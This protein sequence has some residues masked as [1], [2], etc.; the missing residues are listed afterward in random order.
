[1]FYN[2]GGGM[3]PADY[4]AVS[5]NNRGAFGNGEEW[6]FL[7]F[8]LAFAGNGNWGGGNNGYSYGVQQG[9]DQASIM[10]GLQGIQSTLT[11]YQIANNDNMN[12]LAMSLQQCCCQNQLAT[13]NLGAAV[14]SESCATRQVVNDG[15]R[16][17]QM[18]NFQSTQQIVG[19]IN[20]VG[21]N[22]DNKLCQ[23]E[24][25]YYKNALAQARSDLAA[26]RSAASQ[27]AQTAAIV[28][29]NEAQTAAL[30]RT[31]NPTAIPA[32]V[33]PN[34][35]VGGCNSCTYAA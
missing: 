33:V 4:A 21:Q 24:M 35:N 27:N 29:N 32:Y 20:Q 9:F 6:L 15:F 1:M 14:A 13:A 12:S 31:L 3:S 2:N 8:I 23:L 30:I 7:L 34:P 18:Q 22:L 17:M 10:S 28:A 11:A 16:D 25:D 26:E 5:G 19:A